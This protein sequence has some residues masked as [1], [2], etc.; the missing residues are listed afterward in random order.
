M[1]L[2][3]VQIE[4]LL[5]K[6]LL[7]TGFVCT[8]WGPSFN[9]GLQHI[10]WDFKEILQDVHCTINSLI[11]NS[12]KKYNL[13]NSSAPFSCCLSSLLG[14]PPALTMLLPVGMMKY[15]IT[16]TEVTCSAPLLQTCMCVGKDVHLRY[17]TNTLKECMN[18]TTKKAL[19]FFVCP[20]LMSVFVSFD[21]P[22]S[23]CLHWLQTDESQWYTQGSY[24][25]QQP[26]RHRLGPV[27]LGMS[28]FMAWSHLRKLVNNP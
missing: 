13:E 3:T 14:S 27:W 12:G 6:G 18:F 7:V 1:P 11:N 20:L 21:K 2:Q 28:P 16:F 5:L 4:R 19:T 15:V 24:A 10:R 8:V 17:Y 23:S 26:L 25:F 9:E 22:L